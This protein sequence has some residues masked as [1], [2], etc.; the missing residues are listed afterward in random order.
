MLQPTIYR[1]TRP[2]APID[3]RPP[4]PVRIAPAERPVTS[5]PAGEP[6]GSPE[7]ALVEV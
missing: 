2:L 5:P 6:E 3:Q 1:P 4:P 7:P